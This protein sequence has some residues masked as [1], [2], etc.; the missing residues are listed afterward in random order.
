M[1]TAEVYSVTYQLNRNLGSVEN[2]SS[3]DIINSEFFEHFKTKFY[4]E[5]V[6]ALKS[7]AD[8]SQKGD[9]VREAASI[10]GKMQELGVCVDAYCLA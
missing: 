6:D 1:G 7:I 8:Q 5:I 3:A 2:H 10:A 4:A 9:T